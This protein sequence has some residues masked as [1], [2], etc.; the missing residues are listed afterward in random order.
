M[1]NSLSPHHSNHKSIDTT[2]SSWTHGDLCV[3]C[4]RIVE[5]TENVKT[6]SFVAEPSIYFSYQPGQ[7]VSLDLEI[8]GKRIRRAYSISS[9]PTRPH[10]LD[11]TVKRV[12][13]PPN[14]PNVPPG[15]VSNWLHDHLKVGDKIKLSGGPMGKFTCA[16]NPNDKLLFISAGS[17]IT[18]MISMSRWIYDT[19]GKQDVVFV[20]CGRSQRDLI[21]AQELQLIAA[22]QPN[23]RLAISLTQPE[24]GQSWMGYQGRL[25]EQMLLSMVPD[26]RERA[27]YVCGPD[28][29]M[30]GVKT[31]LTKMELPPE[32]YYE[33][34][35]GVGKKQAKVSSS[36]TT[37]PSSITSPSSQP[38]PIKETKS[39]KPTTSEKKAIAFLESGT[40]VTC[41]GEES[42]LAVAQQEGINIRS[43][44][45][46][47]VCGACKKR[48]R[49]GKIRYEAQ[50]D[51]LDKK[52]QEQGYILPC[53]AYP[54]DEVEIEA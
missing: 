1:E 24:P 15:L 47:G 11:I 14:A 22:R 30:K 40:T 48:K 36:S 45:M 46:Q 20:Y 37:S 7:F 21:M 17:G 32:N 52:E 51:G 31:L 42:I 50:P 49:K 6:F 12:P 19:A 23:F 2:S 33:E 27:V 41:D 10:T 8:E 54:V 29:F 4:V 18:P 28:G 34:S 26:F 35:F 3:K 16:T 43:G 9:T 53:V 38:S 5:E 13:A 25:S 39:S 44:C